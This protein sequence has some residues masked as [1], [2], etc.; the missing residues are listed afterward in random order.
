MKTA[1]ATSPSTLDDRF[2]Y[3]RYLRQLDRGERVP[4]T[5]EQWL[6]EVNKL[7]GNMQYEHARKTLNLETDAGKARL[8]GLN[9]FLTHQYPGYNVPNVGMPRT[10]SLEQRLDEFG[11]WAG[12]DILAATPA[13]QALALY[14]ER[15]KEAVGRARLELGSSLDSEAA[16]PLRE[17][18]RQYAQWLIN[19]PQYRDFWP[20]WQSTFGPEIDELPEKSSTVIVGVPT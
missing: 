11:G 20:M 13:G 12:N 4:R 19:Q 14:L 15:R 2:D 17:W 5:P 10:P 8:R 16:R 1:A 9:I 6:R 7:R 3:K 18:L